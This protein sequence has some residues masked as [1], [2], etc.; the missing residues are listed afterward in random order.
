MLGSQRSVSRQPQAVQSA[1]GRPS[2][3]AATPGEW[4]AEA[5]PA[6]ITALAGPGP[7]W[8]RARLDQLWMVKS[9]L[10]VAGVPSCTW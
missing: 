3:S 1:A 4:Q 6:W 10:S 8:T 7:G 9:A 2:A 5:G